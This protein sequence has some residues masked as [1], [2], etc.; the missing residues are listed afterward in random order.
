V[1]QIEFVSM[2]WELS[3]LRVPWLLS[4]PHLQYRQS[5]YEMPRATQSYTC[6]NGNNIKQMI[7][8]VKIPGIS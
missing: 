1:L 4:V 5:L 7:L 3:L 2:F 8:K 6:R